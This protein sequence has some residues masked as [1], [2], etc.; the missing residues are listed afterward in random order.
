MDLKKA[1][2]DILLKTV[3][4]YGPDKLKTKLVKMGIKKG[5]RIMVHSSWLPQNGFEGSAK[6]F[7]DALKDVVGEDGLIVM[8]SMPYQNE[9][10]QAYLSKGLV[11]NRKRTASKVG[12]L[13]E[14]FRRGKAV[15]R[16]FNSA[17]PLLA[18]GAGKEEF[19]E[20]HQHS[21]CSF[22]VGSPFEKLESLRARILLIDAPF[23]TITFNHYLESKYE[24]SYPVPLFESDSMQGEMLDYDG[25]SVTFSTRVLSKASAGHRIDA[26]LKKALDEKSLLQNFRV[27]NTNFTLVD[28][29]DLVSN[30]STSMIS[31][32]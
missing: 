17:H 23:D 14:V 24:D 7:L 15:V 21:I 26:A 1:I 25:A 3:W 16:S 12:L 6:D 4:A 27:G 13:T 8:M 5:D 28:V 9:S 2:K 18:W 32:L 11:F 20:G 31:T 30:V 29:D 19:I 10:T 22:G